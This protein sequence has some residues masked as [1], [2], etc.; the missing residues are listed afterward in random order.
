VTDQRERWSVLFPGAR[1]AELPTSV[2]GTWIS[3][4]RWP[5]CSARDA[6]SAPFRLGA[7]RPW[8]WT[9]T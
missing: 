8:R 3:T 2:F 5:W 6:G 7:R 4:M 1:R 9:A